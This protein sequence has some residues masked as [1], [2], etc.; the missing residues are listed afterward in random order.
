VNGKAIAAAARRL[1]EPAMYLRTRE[2]LTRV[3]GLLGQPGAS[4]RAAQ[5]IAT[6][7]RATD[8][9]ADR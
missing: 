8:T 6:L 1:L 9:G 7:V 3:R 5:K 2:E 4:L